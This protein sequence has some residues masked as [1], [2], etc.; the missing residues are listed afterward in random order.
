MG[1]SRR[2]LDTQEMTIN[3]V[4][5]AQVLMET[6]GPSVSCALSCTGLLTSALTCQER[7]ADRDVYGS[8]CAYKMMNMWTSRLGPIRTESQDRERRHP[9]AFQDNLRRPEERSHQFYEGPDDS[10]RVS[11][12][13][14]VQEGDVQ[15]QVYYGEDSVEQHEDRCATFC[16]TNMRG[17]SYSNS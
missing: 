9:Y 3:K 10:S 2:E 5:E 11:L 14:Y 17:V 16:L 7:S 12:R 4:E 6:E 15:E 1:D 13:L 8:G